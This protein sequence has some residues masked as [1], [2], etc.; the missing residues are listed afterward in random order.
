MSEGVN[1]FLIELALNLIN[2]SIWTRIVHK[3]VILLTKRG[4]LRRYNLTSR[5]WSLSIIIFA[6]FEIHLRW[7]LTH[8]SSE[9]YYLFFH[10]L[11]SA[12]FHIFDFLGASTFQVLFFV[13]KFLVHVEIEGILV[14]SLHI[15]SCIKA[16]YA[17]IVGNLIH[18]SLRFFDIHRIVGNVAMWNTFRVEWSAVLIIII[19]IIIDQLRVR[20]A[21]KKC[22]I[23]TTLQ[24]SFAGEYTVWKM[25]VLL[26]VLLVGNKILR[27]TLF[28]RLPSKGL[29]ALIY[30]KFC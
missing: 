22:K 9:G 19:I 2:S 20:I 21:A 24:T 26:L 5:L 23:L 13:W 15:L 14:R 27:P 7:D 6:T 1:S 16:H 17:I 4:L 30:Q 28:L 25:W 10:E 3:L 11:F 8:L 12:C 18:N 29:W